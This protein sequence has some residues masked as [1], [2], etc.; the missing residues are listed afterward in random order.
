[1]PRAG[2][3]PGGTCTV[4]LESIGPTK[5]AQLLTPAAR[6]TYPL[7]QLFFALSYRAREPQFT[8][9]VASR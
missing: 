5:A 3:T 4:E 7:P 1:M 6:H 9:L 2:G 8:T